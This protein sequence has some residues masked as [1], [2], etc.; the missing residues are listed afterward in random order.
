[1]LRLELLGPFAMSREGPL[2]LRNKKAQALL[3]FLALNPGSHPRERLSALLWPDSSEEAARQSLRQCVSTLRR[4]V[5]DLP[6]SADH[7]LLGLDAANVAIDT[8]E[9]S[10]ALAEPSVANLKRAAALYRGALLDG[11]NARSDLFDEWLLGERT[12][13]R[14]AATSAFRPLLEQ[15]ETSPAREE[16][17]AL[18]LRLLAIDPLQEEVDRAL[19]RLYAEQGRRDLTRRQYDHLCRILL[20]ELGQPP[21]VETTRKYH[22][23]MGPFRGFDAPSI[24]GRQ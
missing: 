3:A 10:R 17:I 6:L 19:M 7:D 24:A 12:R 1:M 18:A 23:F 14:V 21:E 16:A 8:N 4:N 5:A 20:E 9:F 11:L 2:I 13:F 15:L 22:Q